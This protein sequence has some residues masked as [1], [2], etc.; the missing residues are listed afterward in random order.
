M[1][2]FHYHNFGTAL[3]VTATNYTVKKLGYDAVVVQYIPHAK[4]ITLRDYKNF[5]L[6]Y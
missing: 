4:L 6:L 3:Q 1:T 5:F 2:W